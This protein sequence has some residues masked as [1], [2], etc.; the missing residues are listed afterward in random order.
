[1]CVINKPVKR[2]AVVRVDKKNLQIT[3][4]H[5]NYCNYE[6]QVWILY[7]HSIHFPENIR[8]RC[9]RLTSSGRIWILMPRTYDAGCDN[10]M[11]YTI[12]LQCVWRF[13]LK[14]IHCPIR[15]ANAD[16]FEA[17]WFLSPFVWF[18]FSV[19]FSFCLPICRGTKL[20]PLYAR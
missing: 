18:F 4:S 8:F 1:M 19:G 11:N 16:R 9:V 2:F 7:L 13:W 20:P 6:L 14:K 5:Q 10:D 17:K 12:K 3:D 15:E